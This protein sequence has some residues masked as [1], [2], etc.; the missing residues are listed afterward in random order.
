M[1]LAFALL[2]NCWDFAT[3]HPGLLLVLLG[4]AGE[5]IF[6]WKEMK[7]KMAWAKRI[8][9]IVLISGLIL[10]FYE[11]AKSD[12]VVAAS[13][14][15][16]GNAEK[17]AKE[18]GL[19]VAKIGMTNVQLS[20]QIEELHS[21]NFATEKQVEELRKE[22]LQ[23][24]TRMITGLYARS[25]FEIISMN[26]VKRV[27]IQRTAWNTR[28]FVLLPNA[29]VPV[30]INAILNWHV[31]FIRGFAGLIVGSPFNRS[32]PMV[33]GNNKNILYNDI[34]V[35]EWDTLEFPSDAKI[36][37]RYTELEQETNLWK[38]VEIKGHDVYFDNIKQ[39]VK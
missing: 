29:P 16:A 4:V 30:S 18:A 9:A 1:I 39:T 26:D 10:E 8:S 20:F 17:A 21:N 22:N 19:L 35:P 23:L 14:E 38:K 5:V 37:I 3:R 32:L 15:R 34:G 6:D 7:G 2:S 25:H 24:E 11:A 33:F 36:V 31:G 28:I 12:K 13:I 27:T